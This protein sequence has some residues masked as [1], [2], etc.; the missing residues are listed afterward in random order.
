M[1]AKLV[2][3]TIIDVSLFNQFYTY[4]ESDN[5]E[6]GSTFDVSDEVKHAYFIFIKDFCPMVSSHWRK[7]IN[8]KCL[9]RETATYLNQL[10]RS[11]EA[12]SY[13]LILCLEPRVAS[14][15]KLISENGMKKWNDDRKKGKG[16]KHDSNVKFDEYIKIFNKID[17]LRNN[18]KAYAFWMD[19]FFDQFFKEYQK[20]KNIQKEDGLT[21]TSSTVSLKT[22]EVSKTFD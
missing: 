15:F 13:W 17:M 8:H 11:D 10:T 9:V 21:N 3:G 18:E 7:Y 20:K 22:I 6:D 4:E 2:D 16:G 12:F 19:I 5:V 14:D 1:Q